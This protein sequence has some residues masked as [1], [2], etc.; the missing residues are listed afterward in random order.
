MKIIYAK[1]YQ[2]PAYKLILD[3]STVQFLD[4]TILALEPLGRY[5]PETYLRLATPPGSYNEILG[6]I[7]TSAET[8]MTGFEIGNNQSGSGRMIW[9][10]ITPIYQRVKDMPE[11]YFSKQFLER[12]LK[13][14]PRFDL[15]VEARHRDLLTETLASINPER[16]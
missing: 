15:M 4:K 8:Q 1:G 13:E 16:R 2:L 7:V 12:Y 9:E 14:T 3:N 10:A 5:D 11:V 6:R